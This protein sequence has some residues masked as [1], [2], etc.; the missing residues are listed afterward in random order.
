LTSELNVMSAPV[1][2][3]K[4]TP[5]SIKKSCPLYVCAPLVT[6]LAAEIDSKPE[7]LL[8]L[9]VLSGMPPP[10]A[11]ANVTGAVDA[12]ES[13]CAP[14]IVPP[15]QTV[16]APV[17]VTVLSFASVRLLLIVTWFAEFCTICGD[18]APLLVNF[19]A[20]PVSVK[21]APPNVTL[22]R[23][24]GDAMS[25]FGLVELALDENTSSVPDELAGI[26]FPL[27]FVAPPEF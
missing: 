19:N 8:L 16:P 20:L 21:P 11:P 14:S 12:N 10:I 2:L 1:V 3:V 25:W 27:Q 22:F 7:P 5:G 23:L 18:V 17:P 13:A 6:T 15:I 4:L 9:M 26:T 24:N